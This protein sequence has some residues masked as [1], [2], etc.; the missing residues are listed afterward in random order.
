VISSDP[1]PRFAT[2]SAD[3]PAQTPPLTVAEPIL[4]WLTPILPATLVICPPVNV[5]DPRPVEP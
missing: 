2:V 1:V 5:S 4:P 3:E